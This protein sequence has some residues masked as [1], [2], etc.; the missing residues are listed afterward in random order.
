MGWGRKEA[1]IETRQCDLSLVFTP[2]DT[3]RDKFSGVAATVFLFSSLPLQESTQPT[4]R[5]LT[6]TAPIAWQTRT[7]LSGAST[8]A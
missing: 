3:D 4:S 6:H 8:Y 1:F 5:L 2:P 7:S